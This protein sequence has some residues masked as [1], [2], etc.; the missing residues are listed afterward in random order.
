[1]ETADDTVSEGPDFCDSQKK[2]STDQFTVLVGEL[3]SLGKKFRENIADM[4][5]AGR[6][7]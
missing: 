6:Q 5:V 2:L 7:L 1:L 4:S 3:H